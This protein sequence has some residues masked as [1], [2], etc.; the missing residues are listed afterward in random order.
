MI[1][2]GSSCGGPSANLITADQRDRA[3]EGSL[4]AAFAGDATTAPTN[5]PHARGR[6]QSYG[7]CGVVIGVVDCC[8][9]RCGV[10]AC[11]AALATAIVAADC[12]GPVV[13]VAVCSLSQ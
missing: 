12:C 11:A 5:K 8:V 13:S 2:K 10:A 3:T 9:G 7:L 1:I 6:L 4:T